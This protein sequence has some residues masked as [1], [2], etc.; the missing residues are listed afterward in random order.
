MEGRK[1]EGKE[2]RFKIKGKSDS[3]RM[4]KDRKKRNKETV[5]EIRKYNVIERDKKKESNSKKRRFFLFFN[6]CI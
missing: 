2:E 4:R 6:S 1:N 5:R 3:D